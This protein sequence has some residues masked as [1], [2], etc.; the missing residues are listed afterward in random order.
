VAIKCYAKIGSATIY[1]VTDLG[2]G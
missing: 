1:A 2:L